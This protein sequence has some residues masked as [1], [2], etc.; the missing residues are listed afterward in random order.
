MWI[1]IHRSMDILSFYV[2]CTHNSKWLACALDSNHTT[3]TVSLVVNILHRWNLF[4]VL[5][6]QVFRFYS[7]S[8]PKIITENK[9]HSKTCKF[10]YLSMATGKVVRFTSH[11]TTAGGFAVILQTNRATPPSWTSAESGW[12]SNAEMAKNKR[13]YELK[14]SSGEKTLAKPNSRS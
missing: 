3:I 12:T 11:V 1:T 5:S 13:R 4:N 8:R 2:Y 9:W 14:E 10:T 6:L 7:C